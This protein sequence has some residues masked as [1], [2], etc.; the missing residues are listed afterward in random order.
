[1]LLAISAFD[2][3]LKVVFHEIESD[4][5][6]NPIRLA[7]VMDLHGCKYGEN[8]STLVK[9]IHENAPDVILLGGDI[10]DDNVPYKNSEIF[11]SEV[12]AQYPCYYVTGNH[13]FWSG[14]VD[15]ILDII[16]SYGVTILDGKNELIEIN[17]EKINI[18]G[19]SDP[20]GVRYVQNQLSPEE[21]LALLKDDVDHTYFSV[22]LTHRPEMIDEYLKYPYDLAV[23]GHAHGGQWRIPFLLNGLYAPNQGLFPKYAGGFYEF[24]TMDFVVSRGLARE[25]TRV[26]RIWNRPELIFI[27]VV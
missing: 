16:S 25:S 13:E 6:E 23:A 19:L 14:E 24:E 18:S 1:M 15:V 21:Q 11:L 2:V 20:D 12:A 22:L 8:Q 17:G 3:R 9:A 10:F 5:I 4:K 26:P 7:L 27:D